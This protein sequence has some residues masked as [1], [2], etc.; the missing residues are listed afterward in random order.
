M[1]RLLSFL[2]GLCVLCIC[3]GCSKNSSG[4]ANSAATKRLRLAFVTNTTNEFWS[5]VRYGCNSVA[6]N[7]ANVD[8][9]FR[10]FTGSTSE[11]QNNILSDL[12]RKGVDGIAVSPIEAEKQTDFLNQVAAKTLL[13]CRSEEHTSEL[14]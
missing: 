6:H 7:L 4:T 8:V 10:F 5:I 1:K 3:Q 2:L 13:V 11:E 14:Q 12:L 9:D